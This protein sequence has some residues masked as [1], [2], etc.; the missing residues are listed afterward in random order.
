MGSLMVGTVTMWL[1]SWASV[2]P[3]SLHRRTWSPRTSPTWRTSATI[4]ASSCRRP[5]SSETTWRISMRSDDQHQHELKRITSAPQCY[6]I[7]LGPR[8][9]HKYPLYSSCTNLVRVSPAMI[10]RFLRTSGC[11]AFQLCQNSCLS[12]DP[13]ECMCVSCVVYGESV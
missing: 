12:T 1:A 10:L 3:S 6:G 9:M 7:S 5:T 8:L 11:K 13:C 4:W 2:S